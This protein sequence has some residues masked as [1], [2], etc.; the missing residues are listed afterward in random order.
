[1]SELPSG[2]VTMLFSDIEGSTSLL[3]RLG[4]GY[5]AAL[6]VQ[7]EVL[8]AAWDAHGGTEMGTEG[9]SFFVVFET[10][11][12]ALS[13]AI[14]GQ[15]QLA[16]YPWPGGEAVRVRMGVHTGSPVVHDG[17]YVGMDVHR[18]ARIAGAAHGGQLVV[19]AATL[20]LARSHLPAE[21][22]V[23]DLGSHRMRDLPTPEHVFQ[24]DVEGGETGF[25]PLRTLGAS[26]SLP[27]P[28][29]PL[30]GRD[31]E[32]DELSALM[33]ST[34]T[35]LVTLTGPGGSG[36]TRLAISL[37]RRQ[38]EMFADGVYF[39][40][41][42][43]AMTSEAMQRTIAECLGISAD[44]STPA[45]LVSHLEHR[46]T[47]L[48][49]D[50]L[51]QVEGADGVVSELL[52]SSASSSIVATSRRPLHVPGEYEHPV[53]PLEL[54]AGDDVDLVN[55]SGAAQLFAQAARR[56]RS[57]F[58]ITAINAAD[59]ADLCR[60]LD[61]LPLALELA[62]S[63]IR[64]FSART[65][66]G[67]F[68]AA[69]DL[70]AVTASSPDRQKTLRDTIAW[71]HD[72]LSPEQQTLFRRLGVFAAG[73]DVDAVIAVASLDENDVL[74][75]ITGLLDASLLTVS[76]TAEGEPRIGMLETIRAYSLEQLL[77]AGELDHTRARQA[78]HYLD[79]IEGTKPSLDDDPYQQI[80]AHFHAEHDSINEV[81]QWALI[82][83]DSSSRT[84][85][86]FDLGLRLCVALHRPWA[87]S[88]RTREAQHWLEI[89]A[90]GSRGPDRAVLAECLGHAAFFITFTED[91]SRA[92]EWATASIAMWRR[93][94]ASVFPWLPLHALAS[95]ATDRGDADQARMYLEEAIAGE[96]ASNDRDSLWYSLNELVVLEAAQQNVHRALELSQEALSLAEEFGGIQYVLDSRE[97]RANTL[98]HLGRIE[99][100]AT[101]M[102]RVLPKIL[103]LDFQTWLPNFAE[104]YAALC[105]ALGEHRLAVL[106]LGAA[107]AMRERVGSAREWAQREQLAEPI[108]ETRKALSDAEWKA[109]LLEGRALTV[110]QALT[111]AL[112]RS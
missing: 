28:L 91:F 37:A 8:R 50:N 93:L 12:A 109:A 48:V 73:A 60:R 49:L 21:A 20:E 43:T 83:D 112:K 102:H 71:S 23:R 32:L 57:D 3:S 1:M 98:R 66:L 110:E 22:R 38:T 95:V 19:S 100:A 79:R 96:R 55:A 101:E 30:V 94:G 97:V 15:R 85:E 33:H 75:L 56:I 105:V 61:G 72:L 24:I 108:D 103:K 51:E 25:P 82:P 87:L 88:G 4:D 111:Y 89:A 41:L 59:V 2:T 104:D 35:R 36:K 42:S 69:L 80:R 10:A 107:D 14:Q 52:A 84:I 62:A 106:L 11:D 78:R 74:D 86:Q 63:R 67:R 45:A 9:D 58:A 54:P 13:A 18:A 44:I 17:G 27:E 7:R 65:I 47:L 40:A 81:L 39:I 26:T 99:E 64:L 53:P 92:E 34:M 77:L 46:Q 5:A 29:T 76:E 90:E 31:G 68:S 16:T 70:R 6:S